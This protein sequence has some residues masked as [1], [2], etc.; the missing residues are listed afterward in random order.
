[1]IT[2]N[3]SFRALDNPYLGQFFQ[4]IR[5]TFKPPSRKQF[6]GLLDMEYEKVNLTVKEAINKA[7]F[8]A[9]TSD[10]WTDVSRNRLINVIAHAP[11]PMLYN[12]I[13]AT[14]DSHTGE[15]ICKVIAEQ[16][17]KIGARKVIA[18][19]TDNAAN[20]KKAW[21]LLNEM[22]PWILFEGCKAHSIDLAAKDIVNQ[23][24]VEPFVKK[25]ITIAKFFR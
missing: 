4:A 22:F 13:D 14:M 10:G 11:K 16:I 8:I 5:P 6:I 12:T 20:M 15:Y 2:A 19:V 23:V 17:K 7:D 21:R 1:M 24:T 3:I 18:L 9:I 25:C